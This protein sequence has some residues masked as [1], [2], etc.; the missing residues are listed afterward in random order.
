M[1]VA[2][3]SQ[4]F[5]FPYKIVRNDHRKQAIQMLDY[6]FIY[7]IRF[8]SALVSFKKSAWPFYRFHQNAIYL[9]K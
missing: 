1:F 8:S 3:L 4:G 6:H 9:I 7:V 5:E 2:R